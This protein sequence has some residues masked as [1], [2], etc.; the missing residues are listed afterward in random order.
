MNYSQ[1][2]ILLLLTSVPI[3]AQEVATASVQPVFRVLSESTVKH[4]DGSSITFRQ[5]APPVVTPLPPPAPPAADPVLTAA[6]EAAL[7]QLSRKEFKV[8]S[9]S[10]SVHANGFTVLRWTCGESRRLQAVSNVDFRC[11]TGLGNLA[12]EQ[13]DYC[14]ILSAG[15]DEQA[16]TDAEA[17]AAQSLP[18]NGIASCALLS[19][20]TPAGPADESALDAM[21]SLLEYFDTHREEL[22]QRQA[23]REQ[24]RAAR[25]LAALH[26][27]PPPPRHSIVHFWPLQPAQRAAIESSQRDKGATQP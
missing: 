13:A 5:V 15:P 26:A 14:L 2:L 4:R 11:L 7:S 20:S 22:I 8:L 9:I 1:I 27:Q 25:E 3:T 24:E 21:E 18:V 16:M 12:S 6:E 17:L 23:Q 19:G 10:A